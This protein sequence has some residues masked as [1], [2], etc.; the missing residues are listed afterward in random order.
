MFIA[1]LYD[2]GRAGRL[3]SL[4]TAPS[5]T[6]RTFRVRCVTQTEKRVYLNG[7]RENA[8]SRTPYTRKINDG[9]HGKPCAD[10]VRA[11]LESEGELWH[12]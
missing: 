12:R 10:H 2:S 7:E 3:G 1:Y 11:A 8:D 4:P 9:S 6:L 5:V